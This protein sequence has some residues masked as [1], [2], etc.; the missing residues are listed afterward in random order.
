[1]LLTMTLWGNEGRGV[2]ILSCMTNLHLFHNLWQLLPWTSHWIYWQ[3]LQP[4]CH[5]CLH[6]HRLHTSWITPDECKKIRTYQRPLVKEKLLE[7]WSI[8]RW[9][10]YIVLERNAEEYTTWKLQIHTQDNITLFSFLKIIACTKYILI[11]FPLSSA[12]LLCFYKL[13]G[14]PP[15]LSGVVQK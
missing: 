3:S 14:P 1:M 6:G 7:I 9:L 2:C 10:S 8:K 5:L 13:S 15:A 4:F 11:R 12:T